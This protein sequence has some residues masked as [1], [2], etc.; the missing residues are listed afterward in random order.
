MEYDT[1]SIL[2]IPADKQHPTPNV[3]TYSLTGGS[4]KHIAINDRHAVTIEYTQRPG[5]IEVEYDEDDFTTALPAAITVWSIDNFPTAYETRWDIPAFAP[6]YGKN[7]I[8]IDG[9]LIY[10]CQGNNGVAVY[11]LQVLMYLTRPPSR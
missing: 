8:A 5:D 2:I 11:D 10:S 3:G 4:A 7:V 6:V 9:D 1:D